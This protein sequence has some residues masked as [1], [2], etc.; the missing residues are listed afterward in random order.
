MSWRP[1]VSEAT[2]VASDSGGDVGS[3][4]DDGYVTL[5]DRKKELIIDGAGKSP[6]NIEAAIKSSS[7]QI[8]QARPSGDR[9]RY[10]TALIVLDPDHAPAVAVKHGIE[11]SSLDTLAANA[12]VRE[13]VEAGIAAADEKLARVEQL[14]SSPSSQEIGRRTATDSRRR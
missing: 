4:D 2:D 10:H 9:D 7:P 8:D 3:M 5:L 13:A 12:R 14:R 1:T 6:A 11:G